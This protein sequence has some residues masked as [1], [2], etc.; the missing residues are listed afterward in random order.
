MLVTV[1]KHNL[2]FHSWQE[3]S[4]SPHVLGDSSRK[5]DKVTWIN[6]TRQ[7]QLSLPTMN[8]RLP[9]TFTSHAIKCIVVLRT[10]SMRR[11]WYRNRYPSQLFVCKNNPRSEDEESAYSLPGNIHPPKVNVI[12]IHFAKDLIYATNN[13]GKLIPR[14]EPQGWIRARD[15][16]C[17]AHHLM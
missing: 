17:D 4:S 5:C 13:C 11:R 9:R 15:A 7:Y 10:Q 14:L 2:S 16:A 3:N 1:L 8:D 12:N 6:K